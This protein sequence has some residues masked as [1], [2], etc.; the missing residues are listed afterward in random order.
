MKVLKCYS[1]WLRRFKQADR[2]KRV[3]YGKAVAGKLSEMGIDDIG[4]VR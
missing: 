2:L 1:S 3:G 4:E